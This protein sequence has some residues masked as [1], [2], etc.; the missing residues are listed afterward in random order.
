MAERAAAL[1]TQPSLRQSLAPSWK[2]KNNQ[3]I[4]TLFIVFFTMII[5]FP[6]FYREGLI[7]KVC[8]WSHVDPL[9]LYAISKIYVYEFN[10]LIHFSLSNSVLYI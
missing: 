4:F 3:T 9:F 7:A 1:S 2:V 6:L 8:E 5:A 10:L